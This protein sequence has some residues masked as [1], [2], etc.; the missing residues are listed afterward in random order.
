MDHLIL[1]L[2][3]IQ[4]SDVVV[5][6]SKARSL[7]QL[8]KAGFPVPAGVCLT[9]KVFFSA[10][11]SYGADIHKV[12]L[13]HD[14][15]SISQAERVSQHIT[16]MLDRLTVSETILAELVKRWPF[17]LTETLAVRSSAT[18]ED[19][20]E[21]SYAGQ[22][23]T[24]L[25][26]QGQISLSEAIV[27][28]WKSFYSANALMMRA[29]QGALGTD[30][31]MAV[32]IQPLIQAECAGVC[33]SV[34]P[35]LKQPD[36]ILINATWGLGPGIIDGTVASDTYRIQRERFE[37]IER[38]IAVKQEQ[39]Q[40]K[41]AILSRESVPS[42][43]QNAACLPENWAQRIAQFALATEI[44]FGVP[45]DVEWAIADQQVWVLQSR[46]LTGLPAELMALQPFSVDLRNDTPPIL[47]HRLSSAPEP[48][49]PLEQDHI[50]IQEEMR[51]ET[52][53]FMGA[54]RNREIRFFSG[55][56]YTR[57]LGLN[58]TAG[59]IRIRRQAMEDLRIRLHTQRLTAWDYWGPEIV[60][61]TERLRA[62]NPDGADGQALAV[63]LEDAIA[64]RR[65][66]YML[67]PMCEF[68]LPPAFFDA[69]AKVTGLTGDALETLGYQLI[70][71]E[72]T[73]LTRLVDHLYELAELAADKPHLYAL[74]VELPRNALE[75][76]KGL[77]EAAP[78]ITR[79]DN[80]L[81]VYGD[82][83]GDGYG[84][85]A[86][87]ATPTWREDPHQVLELV[88]A[89]LRTL[90]VSPAMARARGQEAY[91]MRFE[92]LCQ[93]SHDAEAVAQLR[94]EYKYASRC[95][96]VLEIHNHYIDQMATGQL[97]QAV[98]NA[99][100]WMIGRGVLNQANDILWLNFDEILTALRS[101]NFDPDII[102]TRQQ[103]YQLWSE[104]KAP[105]TL[106]V[107]LATLAAR[108]SYE[109]E[110]T[111]SEAIHNGILQGMGAS[112]GLYR[113]RACVVHGDEMPLTEVLPGTVLVAENVGPRWTPLFPLLG[114]LV[115]EGGAIGQHAAAT[116]RE[117]GVPAVIGA[118]HATRLIQSNT[119]ISVNGTTGEVQY[120]T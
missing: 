3:E 30:E 118:K 58:I 87:I 37:V 76:L 96:A 117:Y 115:L 97:R 75:R 9:T 79:L 95:F 52:C 81:S 88:A 24:V 15:T 5:T 29:A 31:G 60:S 35:I 70:Q 103:Q 104:M 10:L 34:D 100:H 32:V 2:D 12:I 47:W 40:I 6:G 51:D 66:H 98:M 61:A 56:A 11:D 63:H 36:V 43:L 114:A 89:Y 82:R 73:P 28:C 16:N 84:S 106:G 54:D 65:R 109:T 45:Q 48:T 17:L 91:L 23:T 94:R 110:A 78:F 67:H 25:G 85:E 119:D 90:Q 22:Y 38:H 111:S 83:T 49:L 4:A 120:I 19:L 64:V 59:D 108:L 77:S 44:L 92:E 69:L 26:V 62:F 1:S 14:L 7:A 107:P 18:A 80:L 27:T 116:A 13:Q 20:L 102:L 41:S 42:D 8:I 33:F 113:G 86:T 21:S 93:N 46:P 39:I 55:R 57:P 53:R 68:N 71:S 72:A 101:D 112:P 50:R 99:A 74:L 105:P